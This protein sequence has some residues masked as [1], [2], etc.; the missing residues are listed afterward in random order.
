M[1]EIITKLI[2]NKTLSKIFSNFWNYKAFPDIDMYKFYKHLKTDIIIEHVIEQEVDKDGK[3]YSINKFLYYWHEDS[4]PAIFK[5]ELEP[6]MMHCFT[7]EEL[8]YRFFN[9]F[10][11]KYDFKFKI[12]YHNDQS[13]I[14]S[15]SIVLKEKTINLK[16]LFT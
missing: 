7:D 4:L 15:C 13:F 14:K 10:G 16:E 5:K 12:N 9:K 6:A 2:D 1:S 8:R 11:N 3:F